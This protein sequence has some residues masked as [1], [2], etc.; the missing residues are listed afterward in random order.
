MFNSVDE[1]ENSSKVWKHYQK[2]RQEK[3]WTNEY[4]QIL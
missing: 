4:F 3:N 1:Y 2:I